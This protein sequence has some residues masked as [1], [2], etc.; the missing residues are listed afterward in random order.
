M[1]IQPSLLKNEE[2]VIFALREIYRAYGYSCF[3][4]N[5][6]EEYDLYSRHKDFLVSERVITFTDTDGKL[7]A[8][9]PDVTLSIVKNFANQREG[10]DEVKR[11][12]YD[13]TVYR[14]TDRSENYKEIMQ[15]GIECMGALDEYHVLEVLLLA[16]MSLARISPDSVLNLSNLDVLSLVLEG[17]EAQARAEIMAAIGQKNT[18]GVHALCERFGL[19]SSDADFLCALTETAGDTQEIISSLLEKTERE[20]VKNAL[21]RLGAAAKTTEAM[22]GVRVQIDFSVATD[23]KYYNGLVYRGFV[24]GVPTAVLSGGQYDRL[25]HKMGKKASAVGFAVYLD[26]LQRMTDNARR[27]DVDVLLIYSE[28]DP[29]SRVLSEALAYARE[30][31]RVSVQKE[32]PKGLSFAETAYVPMPLHEEEVPNG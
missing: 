13:E 3:K 24:M 28:N 30:G 7:M 4:M 9:K 20:D 10:A 23:G 17:A 32:V 25:L 18:D 8:L 27:Y 15:T 16:G 31:K 29:P 19:S 12:Y 11:V 14:A 5:K 1:Q 2:A 21:L 6:F 22:A 26:A